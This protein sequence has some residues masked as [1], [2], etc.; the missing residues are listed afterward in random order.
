[1][2]YDFSFSRREWWAAV[3]GAVLF[4]VMMF[5]FGFVSGALW[6]RRS[7]PP[8]KPDVQSQKTSAFRFGGGDARSSG[9]TRLL[10]NAPPASSC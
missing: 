1:M 9:Y 6:Q 7:A 5:A 2:A 4:A 3:A 8:Q 10:K